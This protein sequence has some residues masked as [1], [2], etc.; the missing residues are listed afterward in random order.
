MV[1]VFLYRDKIQGLLR[2]KS[3]SKNTF[4]GPFV[5]SLFYIYATT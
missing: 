3:I 2:K 4:I 1:S 5:N